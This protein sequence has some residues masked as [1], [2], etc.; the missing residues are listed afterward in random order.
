MKWKVQWKG[1]TI[2]QGE[3]S[4]LPRKEAILAELNLPQTCQHLTIVS[5]AVAALAPRDPRAEFTDEDGGVF[6]VRFFDF[7]PGASRGFLISPSSH[8]VWDRAEATARD[9]KNQGAVRGHIGFHA[10]WPSTLSEWQ[11]SAV[12]HCTTEVKALVKGYGDLVLGEVGWRSERMRIVSVVSLHFN[13]IVKLYPEL[14]GSEGTPTNTSVSW[15]NDSVQWLVPD[16][17]AFVHPK[18]AM[19]AL[20][21]ALIDG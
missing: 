17:K 7:Y 21:R 8:F 13:E 14:S 1:T 12:D 5:E 20:K 3:S 11:K 6:G 9:W 15:S 4:A 2:G 19:R 10:A 18:L 16:P